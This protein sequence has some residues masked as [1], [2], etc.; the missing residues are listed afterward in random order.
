MKLHWIFLGFVLLV[1][2][3]VACEKNTMDQPMTAEENKILCLVLEKMFGEHG[4]TVVNPQTRFPN[5]TVPED[6]ASTRKYILEQL[7]IQDGNLASLLDQLIQRNMQSQTL[8]ITSC[9]EKGYVVDYDGKYAK[10]FDDNGGGWE[11]WYKE[12]PNAH[13]STTVSIPVYDAKTNLMLIY[14]GTQA[15]YLAGAGYL[16]VYE[17]QD[18]KLTEL[19]RVMLWIS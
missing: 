9:L 13:G 7:S 2:S 3:S 19:G 18:G 11:Q 10:Y 5:I 16:I 17:Y 1:L 6:L 15:D 14:V 8:T 4:Y 12:N